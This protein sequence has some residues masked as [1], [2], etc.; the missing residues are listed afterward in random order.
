[1]FK[2]LTK[3]RLNWDKNYAKKYFVSNI[4]DAI[5]ILIRDGLAYVILIY[6]F[7]KGNITVDNFVLYFSAVNGFANWIGGMVSKFT[8]INEISLYI[9]D[10]RDYL[11]Y[12]DT[13][14][15]GESNLKVD[16]TNPSEIVLEN[17]YYRYEGASNDAL[18]DISIKIKRG[19]KIAVVGLNG[20]GKTTLIKIICGLY[21]PIKGNVYINGFS[22]NDYN[23]FDY[24]SMFATVFQDFH[25]LPVSIANT[26]SCQL[27]ENTNR[28]EVIKCLDKVGLIEKITE[29]KDGIDSYLNKQLNED[30]I[31]LSGGEEQKLLLARALY[32]NAP[33]LILDEPTAALDPISEN[34][35]YQKYNDLTQNK[36]SIYISHR[37]SS[38]KFCDRILYLENGKIVEKGTHEEL[39]KIG[40]RYAELFNIQSQ[41]YQEKKG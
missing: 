30:G 33:I 27:D 18:S 13:I 7:A 24:Y 9:C 23:I 35:L 39:M 3:E 28:E 1:M 14:N 19:E 12:P 32:K 21:Q 22:K 2:S 34:N 8:E 40:G 10:L 17:V 25:F 6:Y 26:I 36:T 38:T 5:I 20:A 11:N 41:Y 31:E 37:L 15:N 29:L 16:M 4:I